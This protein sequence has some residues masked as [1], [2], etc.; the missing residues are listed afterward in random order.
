[1]SHVI[2]M[3]A[4]IVIMITITRATAL[5]DMIPAYTITLYI[6][7]ALFVTGKTVKILLQNFL[8][9]GKP[10]N[11]EIVNPQKFWAVQ[12]SSSTLNNR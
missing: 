5:Y 11:L 1:M 12:Y 9:K 3:D 7:C 8:F 10:L 4:I 6:K 2:L